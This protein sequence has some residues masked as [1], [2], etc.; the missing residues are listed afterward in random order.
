MKIAVTYE[1][2]DLLRLVAQDLQSQGIRVKAGTSL[3]YK[4]ALEVKLLVETE[5][6][7]PLPRAAPTRDEKL[8]LAAPVTPEITTPFVVEE[9]GDVSSVVRASNRI[10][11]TGRALAPNESLEFPRE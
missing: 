7:D 1:K 8:P 3:E 6:G 11:K 9:D 10:I 4:G 5:E 2:K